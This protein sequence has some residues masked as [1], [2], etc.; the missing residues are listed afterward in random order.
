MKV[1]WSRRA[2]ADLRRMN[3]YMAERNPRAAERM[4]AR[5]LDRI[6]ALRELPLVG[7]LTGVGEARWV[8]VRRTQFI[9]GA[10]RDSRPRTEPLLCG[11]T[12]LPTPTHRIRDPSF[13]FPP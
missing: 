5:I 10:G 13:H 6:E 2:L 11:L 3:S 7:V 1:R 8:R 4:E 12:A 9:T